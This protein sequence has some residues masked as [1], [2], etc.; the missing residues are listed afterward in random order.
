MSWR[1]IR[2]YTSRCCRQDLKIALGARD[3]LGRA[4]ITSADNAVPP[5]GGVTKVE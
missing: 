2:R 4:I 1:H 5:S 3:V